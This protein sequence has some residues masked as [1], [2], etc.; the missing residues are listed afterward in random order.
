MQSEAEWREAE[1]GEAERAFIR[2]QTFW[3]DIPAKQQNFKKHCQA[4]LLKL[5]ELRKST[6]IPGIDTIKELIDAFIEEVQVAEYE[7]YRYY[8][9]N[10]SNN[11]SHRNSRKSR[12]SR[13]NTRA[14]ARLNLYNFLNL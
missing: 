14:G 8:N 13:K 2:I 3:R 12:K 4:T 9:S 1:R 10:S 11:S 5:R 6:K 7:V